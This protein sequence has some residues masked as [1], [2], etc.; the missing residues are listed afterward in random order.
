MNKTLYTYFHW[1]PT[2]KNKCGGSKASNLPISCAGKGNNPIFPYFCLFVAQKKGTRKRYRRQSPR[3]G[4]SLASRCGLQLLMADLVRPRLYS[5]CKCGNNVALH[6]DVISKSFQGRKGRAF[7]FSHVMNISIGPKANRH[8]IT[9][10]HTIADVK[11][12]ECSEVLGWKY[13]KAY[14]EAQKYK[15]GKFILE[16][17]KIVCENW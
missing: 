9:G 3:G 5:C 11:C 8:L 1:T 4:R 14:E 17:S 12:S 16:N 7:L 10:L 15:E 6:D 2:L 13:Q